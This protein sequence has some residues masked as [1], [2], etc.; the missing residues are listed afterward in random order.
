MPDHIRN[1]IGNIVKEIKKDKKSKDKILYIVE[2][3]IDKRTQSHI[4]SYRLY[5]KELFFYVDSSIW[6]YEVNLR[7]KKIL[8]ELKKEKM[9]VKT[10]KIK[11]SRS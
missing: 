1:L 3:L 10:I 2:K 6:G 11:L 9:G 8:D 5:K 4:K 7:R